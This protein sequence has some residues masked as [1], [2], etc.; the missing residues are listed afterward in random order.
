MAR[1]ARP[2]AG[3]AT[4]VSVMAAGAA[5]GRGER[6]GREHRVGPPP[7][8]PRG[9]GCSRGNAMN[10]SASMPGRWLPCPGN[11]NATAQRLHACLGARNAMPSTAPA[12]RDQLGCEVVQVVGDERG[13]D[14]AGPVPPSWRQRPAAAR[15]GPRR[16]WPRAAGQAVSATA[17]AG[18][19]P[20]NRKSSAGHSCRPCRGSGAP[21]YRR[22]RRGSSCRRTRTRSLRRPSRSGRPRVAGEIERERAAS[23]GSQ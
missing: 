10:R 11:R 8:E 14:R 20:R 12:G 18:S 2:S 19:A 7:A 1:P 6:G 5:V 9:A 23:R 13:P 16:R 22:A 21:S 15:G 3:W 17:A 4:R